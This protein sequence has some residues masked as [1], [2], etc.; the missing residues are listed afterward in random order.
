MRYKNRLSSLCFLFLAVVFVSSS[1]SALDLNSS[2]SLQYYGDGNLGLEAKTGGDINFPGV[3]EFSSSGITFEQP[4]SVESSGP[5]SVGSGIDLTDSSSNTIE[6]YSTFYLTTSSGS[7]SDIVLDPTGEVGVSSDLNIGGNSITDTSGA[8]TLDSSVETTG[9]LNM[10]GNSITSFFGSACPSGEVVADI[11]DNGNFGC[12]NIDTEIQDTY[13]NRNGDTMT[14]QLDLQNN[15]IIGIGNLGGSGIVNS[16][17]IASNA[18]TPNELDETQSYSLSWNNLG[19]SQSDITT[20]DL[21]A[22]DSNINLNSNQ[23][24]NVGSGNINLG[25]GSGDINMNG[26]RIYGSSLGHFQ[27][28]GV[29]DTLTNAQNNLDTL[30]PNSLYVADDVSVGGDFIGTGG[31]VAEN[32]KTEEDRELEPGTVT[33]ISGDVEVKPATEKRDT[34]VAGVVS[35]DPGVK[36]AKER[37]GVPLALSGVVPVKTTVENGEIEP[38]DLLTTSSEEGYAMKCQDSLECHGAILGKAMGSL[39]EKGKVETLVTLG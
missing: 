20:N 27:S 2:E 21:G 18:V 25:D 34:G 8:L 36:L 3:A 12:V 10:N 19:I 31:D 22:A 24:N 39:D 14:G 29:S 33:T 30:G 17:N 26:Q 35:T 37:D 6:S 1:A 7:A 16:N 9:D 11:N 32:I 15:N 5:F 13:V 38:G 23:I 28:A 4:L